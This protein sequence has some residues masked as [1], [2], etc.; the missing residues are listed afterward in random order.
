MSLVTTSHKFTEL[1]SR[2]FSLSS[3]AHRTCSP[4]V[5]CC[6]RASIAEASS[7]TISAKF[8][9]LALRLKS[10]FRDQFIGDTTTGTG[11][12]P[13]DC[14]R[15]RDHLTLRAKMYSILVQRNLQLL[16]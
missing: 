2:V 16:A 6:T 10:A 8:F 12:L 9:L 7:T 5:S 13:H 1:T 15:A 11:I 14:L 4:P 3:N